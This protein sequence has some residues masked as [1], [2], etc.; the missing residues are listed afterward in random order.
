M[1][2]KIGDFIPD[3]ETPKERKA[4]KLFLKK[5]CLILNQFSP[6]D[7]QIIKMRFGLDTGCGHTLKEIELQ[8]NVARQYIRKI[9]SR[10]LKK[11]NAI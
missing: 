8:F 10:I 5:L 7:Q 2:S 1:A 3:D 4:R 6:K 11:L 9:E